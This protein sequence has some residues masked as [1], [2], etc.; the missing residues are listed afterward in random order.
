MGTAFPGNAHTHNNKTESLTFNEKNWCETQ[1]TKNDL[2]IVFKNS[3][4]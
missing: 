4:L 1:N 3:P 2:K